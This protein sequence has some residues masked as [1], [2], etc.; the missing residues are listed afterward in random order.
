V[1]NNKHFYVSGMSYVEGRWASCGWII[2]AENFVEAS[3][4][5]EADEKFRVHSISDNVNY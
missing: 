1:D 5:A 4:I 2:E 3:K